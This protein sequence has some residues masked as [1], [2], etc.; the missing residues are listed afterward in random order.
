MPMKALVS[1]REVGE[2]EHRARFFAHPLPLE[3]VLERRMRLSR[4]Y[5]IKFR[6][7]VCS[8]GVKVTATSWPDVP[9]NT[10]PHSSL[11]LVANPSLRYLRISGHTF[12]CI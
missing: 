1:E 10:V 4:L 6:C 9:S 5:F 7:S 11:V 3:K 12:C 2:V 8:G